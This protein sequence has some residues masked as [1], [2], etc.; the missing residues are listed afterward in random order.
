MKNKKRVLIA[1]SLSCAI[2]L[3]SAA[4]TQANSAHKD[5]QD[6]NKKEHVDKSQQKDKRNVTN[7]DKNSTAPDDIGKNGKITKRTETV[8]DEKTNILQNLQ[9]DF[10][11][12]PTYDKNVL[13]VKKQGSIHSNLKFESHKEEKNSNWLKYPSEYH[14][15]FQVKRNRKTEILDQLP[16][17]KISTAKV[18]STF[19]YSSGGKFDSTKGIGRTSSNSYSKTISYNQQNYDTIASGKNN[20]WHV[21]WS[22]IANDLKYGGEVKNRNDELLF[23]RNTRIATVKNPE[24][25]FASKYRYPAL[26]RSG[27]NPEFL[28]Y[29]SNEKSNEK[30]QFEV[31]YT[32]NQDIL[33]NRPGIHYAPPILEKNKDGQRLIVTYEVD[34][35]NKTV[36]VVDKYSDDN[37]PYKEG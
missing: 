32:R 33:K 22:V 21:H 18:D 34:W 28:T 2:L 24:L 16:K 37:K 4:T 6:Q 10:I 1:S 15:D 36:K 29:L 35:K 14:V 26:V 7:K 17:N 11:D 3:L 30:T 12:D 19:S 13:L 31:T 8:Y 20:N 23:Y 25:S 5:S 9:F 27:F